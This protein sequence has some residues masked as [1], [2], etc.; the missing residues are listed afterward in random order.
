MR[1]I[2]ED[3]WFPEGPVWL[4]DGSLLVVEIR[5]QTL[6][7]VWLDGR[8]TVVAEL[9]G[10]PNGAAIGPDGACYVCNNGGFDWAR[11]DAGAY[12]TAGAALNYSGGRIEKVDI[13]TGEFSVLYS[14]ANGRPLRGPNDLVFDAHGGF[15]FTDTG[16]TRDRTVERGVVFYARADGS[17]IEEI[18]FPI[19]RPNGVGLSADG[20]T[21]YVSETETARVWAWPLTAP[22][23]LGVTVKASPSSPHGGRLVHAA[24]SY[25]RFDSLAVDSNGDVCV[26]TLDR[27][28]ITVCSPDGSGSRF[29]PIPGDTHATNICFGG[30]GLRRAYVTQG[31]AGRLVEVEWPVPGLPLHGSYRPDASTAKSR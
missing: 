23:K 16:K 1:V 30:E 21:L 8:K 24:S 15:Y 2:A 28:G 6:T 5:R 31:Y 13:D 4:G 18:I 11:N 19:S 17:A 12:A 20:K 7:R 22:G 29:V 25:M 10:G 9:G 3:L 26:G 14:E 27:G